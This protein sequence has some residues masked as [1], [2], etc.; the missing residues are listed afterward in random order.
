MHSLICSAKREIRSKNDQEK[1]RALES[2]GFV[3]FRTKNW[4]FQTT[5]S[6]L[7]AYKSLFG[8]LKI[9]Q[10]FIV[11]CEAPWPVPVRGM[12]LGSKI[13]KIRQGT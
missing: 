5:I 11:P 6:A 3:V 13:K 2:V 10:K 7:R 1:A 4:D 9:S 12:L 8:N